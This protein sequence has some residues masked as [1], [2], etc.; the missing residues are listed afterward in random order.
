VVSQTALET[1]ARQAPL[2][3]DAEEGRGSAGESHAQ[4]QEVAATAV[5]QAE[6]KIEAAKK[7]TGAKAVD[8]GKAIAAPAKAPVKK[9]PAK[10]APAKKAGGRKT[11]ANKAAAKATVA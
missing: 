2:R 9:V 8:L 3:R 7:A 6:G 11:A 4:G 10:K 1:R 5:R